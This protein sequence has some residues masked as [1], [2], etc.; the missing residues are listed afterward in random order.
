MVT[1]KY[2]HTKT[3]EIH[4]AQL[5]YAS[6]VNGK[7]E[8]MGVGASETLSFRVIGEFREAKS[9]ENKHDTAV[10]IDDVRRLL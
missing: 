10:F 5:F 4:I 8:R 9:F 7:S 6:F 2:I 1:C 3:F